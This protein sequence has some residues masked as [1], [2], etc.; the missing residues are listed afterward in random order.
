MSK[1]DDD[2]STP[3]T[4]PTPEE[5]LEHFHRAGRRRQVGPA[6]VTPEICYLATLLA[7]GQLAKA[8]RQVTRSAHLLD[9][10][11]QLR[12]ALKEHVPELKEA[13]ADPPT[14]ADSAQMHDHYR[15]EVRDYPHL[16]ALLDAIDKAEPTRFFQQGLLAIIRQGVVEANRKRL[17][18]TL[19]FTA[20]H[21]VLEQS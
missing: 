21:D 12:A 18:I 13:L 17:G 11:R 2:G 5:V 9:A 14:Q 1:A 7:P 19:V 15:K 10:L 8:A 3:P 16:R 4:R 6:Q 20:V